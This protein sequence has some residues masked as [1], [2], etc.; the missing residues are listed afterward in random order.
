MYAE[1]DDNYSKGSAIDEYFYDMQEKSELLSQKELDDYYKYEYEDELAYYESLDEGDST[2]SDIT[3]LS[4]ND[5][6]EEVF[7]EL[8]DDEDTELPFP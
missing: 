2:E 6:T 4:K 1:S 5:Y 3:D 7:F 8:F